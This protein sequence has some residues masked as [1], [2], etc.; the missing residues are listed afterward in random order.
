MR[1]GKRPGWE[2]GVYDEMRDTLTTDR[3][4]RLYAL[5]KITI[6]PVYGQINTTAASNVEA[7]PLLRPPFTWPCWGTR[8]AQSSRSTAQGDSAKSRSWI[9]GQRTPAE[10]CRCRRAR[11]NAIG[12]GISSAQRRAAHTT[13]F[14]ANA[15]SRTCFGRDEAGEQPD[16]EESGVGAL[17][18]PRTAPGRISWNQ[19]P[20]DRFRAHDHSGAWPS[21]KRRSARRPTRWPPARLTCAFLSRPDGLWLSPSTERMRRRLRAVG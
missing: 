18:G 16:V 12:R 6:E 19:G 21:Q 4:R 15:E 1:E 8:L 13:V 7:T 11:T 14:S 20:D 3:G 10:I 17:R 2:H 5:R 9:L